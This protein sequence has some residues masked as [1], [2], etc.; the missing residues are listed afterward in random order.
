M[1]EKHGFVLLPPLKMAFDILN[2]HMVSFE[3]M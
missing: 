3:N 2:I 1:I